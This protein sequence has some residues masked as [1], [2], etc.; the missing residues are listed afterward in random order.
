MQ[1]KADIDRFY[2]DVE[3]LNL[4]KPNA[5]IEKETG[6][7]K[8]SISRYLNR[9]EIP[10]ENFLKVFYEKFGNSLGTVS[11]ST[12]SAGNET[13]PVSKS[14]L[15]QLIENNAILVRTIEKAQDNLTKAQEDQRELIQLLKANSNPAA[16]E[17]S[18]AL[19][20]ETIVDW[21]LKIGV[22]VG[23]FP[24]VESGRKEIGK[25]LSAHAARRKA[26]H[27]DAG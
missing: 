15:A 27:N 12:V 2:S 11:R 6:W 25:T 23:V 3:K 24:T 26:V 4:R 5:T 19:V 10:S 1:T 7:S 17:L 13:H 20:T 8:G 21:L 14:E 16:R 18:E 22:K 9:K